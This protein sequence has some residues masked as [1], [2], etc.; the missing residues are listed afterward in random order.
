MSQAE[1]GAPELLFGLVIWMARGAH[2]VAGGE[3]GVRPPLEHLAIFITY[4]AF[5]VVLVLP[6]R[7]QAA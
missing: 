1:L 3:E 5:I 4:I 7:S 2:R 6:R